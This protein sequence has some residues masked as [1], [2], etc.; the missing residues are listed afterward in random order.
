VIRS[1]VREAVRA[2]AVVI[3]TLAA[4]RIAGLAVPVLHQLVGALAVA[5]FLYV[6]A[7]LLERTG[8]DAH[9]AGWRFDRLRADAGWAL[10]V[11]AV[12]LPPFTLG[13]WWFVHELPRLP[14]DIATRLAPYVAAAHPLRFRL[15]P[16]PWELAGRIGGN[17]AVAFAEEFFYRGYMTLRLE[18]RWP[19]RRRVL[20]APL[21]GA[22]VI[23]AALFAAGHLLEPAP[24]RLAVFFPALVFAWLR[25]RTGTVVGAAICHFLFNVWL[26]LLERAAFGAP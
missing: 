14:P 18:E 3:G 8:Q 20:G 19:P 23:A 13:F 11:C 7:K 4:V 21:G 15:G 25:A 9:D 5:A 16:D 10:L 22:A 2:W 12:I 17:A 6:P 1:P 24:W 26:L